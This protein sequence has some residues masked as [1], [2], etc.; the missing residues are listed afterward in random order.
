VAGLA[1]SALV[2]SMVLAA[3]TSLFTALS[4]AELVAWLPEEGSIY[5]TCTDSSPQPRGSSGDGCG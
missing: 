2:V 3:V 1:G 5:S 4:Y